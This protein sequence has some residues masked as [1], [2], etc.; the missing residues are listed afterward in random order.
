MT[1][2]EKECAFAAIGYLIEKAEKAGDR[3]RAKELR[4]DYRQIELE[5]LEESHA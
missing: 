3:K 2:H 5:L 4:A 1:A